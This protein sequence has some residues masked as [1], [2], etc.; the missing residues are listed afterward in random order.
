LEGAITDFQADNDVTPNG[1]LSRLGLANGRLENVMPLGFRNMRGLAGTSLVICS[2]PGP[3]TPRSSGPEG[4]NLPRPL[5]EE[6]VAILGM[7]KRATGVALRLADIA[8]CGRASHRLG[9]T[10]VA[11]SLLDGKARHISIGFGKTPSMETVVATA[12]RRSIGRPARFRIGVGRPLTLIPRLTR[13][14]SNLA[15][16]ELTDV[17]ASASFLAVA[18]PR[19]GA[20]DQASDIGMVADEYQNREHTDHFDMLRLAG[21]PIGQA[22]VSLEV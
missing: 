10:Y 21:K 3:V 2:A 17:G 18:N 8:P 19:L 4:L 5:R 13:F 16:I 22:G 11:V 7:V 14:D 15:R 12:L 1:K 6:I 9:L 20:A